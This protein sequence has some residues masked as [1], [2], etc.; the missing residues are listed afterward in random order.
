MAL[1][2]LFSSWDRCNHTNGDGIRIPVSDK[3]DPNSRC[4]HNRHNVRRV[5]PRV[6]ILC[7]TPID[8]HS[9]G[10]YRH[11]IIVRGRKR[12]NKFADTAWGSLV[13]RVGKVHKQVDS[14][15]VELVDSVVQDE[16]GSVEPKVVDNVSWH[17]FVV[18]ELSAKRDGTCKLESNGASIEGYVLRTGR[19]DQ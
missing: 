6:L 15:D 10:T 17:I 18:R 14:S 16:R 11:S 4:I 8:V 3:S 19:S 7:S 2:F 9:L 1:K 5:M 13:S 12:T